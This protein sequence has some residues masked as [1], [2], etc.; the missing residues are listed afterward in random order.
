MHHGVM[1]AN[2]TLDELLDKYSDLFNVEI[3]KQPPLHHTKHYI[4]TQG[5]P[6]CG[7]VRI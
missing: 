1:D 3:F 5:P 7:Q 6:V 4:R 2:L